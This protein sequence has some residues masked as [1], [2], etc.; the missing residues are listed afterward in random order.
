MKISSAL[1]N[2]A[3]LRALG[4]RL[5]AARLAANLTQ[6][7]LAAQAGVAKRTVERL[8][9]GAVAAQLSALLRVCR[10]LGLLERLDHLVPEPGPSPVAQLKL[11]RRARKRATGRRAALA[12]AWTWDKP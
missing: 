2:D 7:Q 12:P 3:V 5:A 10:V 4:A 8:E 9:S 6:A 11:K 1:T